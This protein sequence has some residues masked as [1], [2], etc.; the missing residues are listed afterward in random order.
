MIKCRRCGGEFDALHIT[1]DDYCRNCE[2]EIVNSI[3][4]DDESEETRY[5]SNDSLGAIIHRL[6]ERGT[7]WRGDRRTDRRGNR[8]H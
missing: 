8:R 3:N 2:E 4:T 7:N 6:E 1:D 5:L